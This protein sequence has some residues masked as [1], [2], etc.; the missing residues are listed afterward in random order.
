MNRYIKIIVPCVAVVL[1]L[2]AY[3]CKRCSVGARQEPEIN[4][5]LSP[6]ITS[7]DTF[8]VYDI[9]EGTRFVGSM[10]TSERSQ[11]KYGMDMNATEMNFL[12][13]HALGQDT[14]TL[15][16]KFRSIYESGC[17]FM[18]N[19]PDIEVSSAGTYR[20]SIGSDFDTKYWT[21]LRVVLYY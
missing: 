18:I 3:A 10:D 19:A 6:G 16:Y 12:I 20:Y 17:G 21:G 7:N 8:R 9:S 5:E 4:F 14:L 1:L 11:V 2:C 13:M 15:R